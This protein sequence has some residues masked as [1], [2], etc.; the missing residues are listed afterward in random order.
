RGDY[1]VEQVGIAGDLDARRLAQRDLDRDR[2][3]EV[4][5]VERADRAR[6]ARFGVG[7]RERGAEREDESDARAEAEPQ[8]NGDAVTEHGAIHDLRMRPA[9]G[10]LTSP[11]RRPPSG[12]RDRR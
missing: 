3:G 9:T 6:L 4:D 8:A 12:C 11:R 10:R 5:G 7:V 1:L 2:A